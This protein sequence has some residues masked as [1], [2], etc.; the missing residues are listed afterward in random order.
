MGEI[1]IT[2]DQ[3]FQYG[4]LPALGLIGWFLRTTLTDIR[5]VS[6]HVVSVNSTVEVLSVKVSD[7]ESDVKRAL[8]LGDQLDAQRREL[9]DLLQTVKAL[10][11]RWDD[12]E[13]ELELERERSHFFQNKILALRAAVEKQ[14]EAEFHDDWVMP[15]RKSRRG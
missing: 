7:I 4:I 14:T 9:H 13:A 10:H 2:V 15:V 1:R 3:L 5:K 11:D 12:V 6:R 8:L